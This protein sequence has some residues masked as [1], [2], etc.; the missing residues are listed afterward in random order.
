MRAVFLDSIVAVAETSQ[1]L[2]DLASVVTTLASNPNMTAQEIKD[3]LD[4][5]SI[6]YTLDDEVCI[7]GGRPFTIRR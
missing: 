5:V 1:E 4:N 7:I 6:P 2:S 3:E